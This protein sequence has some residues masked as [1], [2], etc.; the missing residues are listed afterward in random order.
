MN[1]GIFE[2][3]LTRMHG[4][5]ET[6]N[7][8]KTCW[9]GAM[10]KFVPYAS[11]PIAIDSVAFADC[12]WEAILEGSDD[13]KVL[14]NFQ[15]EIARCTLSEAIDQLGVLR[16]EVES[17]V[18]QYRNGSVYARG[19]VLAVWKE[20]RLRLD[21][22]RHFVS[23]LLNASDRATLTSELPKVF[24]T[25]LQHAVPGPNANPKQN[26]SFLNA[27]VFVHADVGGSVVARWVNLP[28][29]KQ[30]ES[31]KSNPKNL[32]RHVIDPVN[33][34]SIREFKPKAKPPSR[35]SF[36][37]TF[38]EQ[39]HLR[40]PNVTLE[41]LALPRLST[42]PVFRLTFTQVSSVQIPTFFD[43]AAAPSKD[44]NDFFFTPPLD[45]NATFGRTSGTPPVPEVVA[46]TKLVCITAHLSEP[47][48][49]MK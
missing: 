2:E 4:A 23:V 14:S 33:L 29:E 49:V 18:N 21:C 9:A 32:I 22:W 30:L 6:A 35:G 10:S 3:W 20:S 46:A 34:S 43:A 36:F 48:R 40:S 8:I 15:A 27:S 47:I 7:K 45:P 38:D 44:A 25:H 26:Q 42:S 5:G 28:N 12:S 39:D 41:S 37:L 16:T 13:E 1:F 17:Q 19:F 31:L 24:Q 11:D